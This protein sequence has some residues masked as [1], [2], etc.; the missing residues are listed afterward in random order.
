MGYRALLLSGLLGCLDALPICHLVAA[1]ASGRETG[2][3]RQKRGK[4]GR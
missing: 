1:V 2:G 3:R 4:E